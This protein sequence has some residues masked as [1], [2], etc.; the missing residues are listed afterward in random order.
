MVLF[1]IF[2]DRVLMLETADLAEFKLGTITKPL[3][4]CDCIKK[5]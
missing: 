3:S 4:Y 2:D 5:S 1:Q